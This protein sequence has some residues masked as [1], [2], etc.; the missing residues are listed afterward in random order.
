MAVCLERVGAPL[1][2]G[3]FVSAFIDQNISPSSSSAQI[4]NSNV[5]L[6]FFKKSCYAP[7]EICVVISVFDSFLLLEGGGGGSLSLST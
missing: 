4:T 6:Y 7:S 1:W 3:Q 2:H 5:F